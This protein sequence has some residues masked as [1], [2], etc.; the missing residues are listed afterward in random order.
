MR[1]DDAGDRATTLDDAP[2]VLLLDWPR[3]E[4]LFGVTAGGELHLSS[5][6]GD[7]WTQVAETPGPPIAFDAT[8]EVW[9][10]ATEGGVFASDDLGASWVE[11]V[12]LAMPTG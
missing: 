4:Q 9:H 11:V 8:S 1:Y 5:D 10:V 3:A 2:A 6:A 7:S 12:N